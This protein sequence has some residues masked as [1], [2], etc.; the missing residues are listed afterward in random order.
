[1][2]G[3]Q[4]ITV[5]LITVPC[6]Y[7]FGWSDDRN[8]TSCPGCNSGS[9]VV[10][11]FLLSWCSFCMIFLPFKLSHIY[12]EVH[13]FLVMSGEIFCPIMYYFSLRGH[14]RANQA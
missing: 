8:K 9:V 3:V 2:A 1:M 12:I 7:V 6:M 14:L 11:L 4:L 5:D 10:A 13:R